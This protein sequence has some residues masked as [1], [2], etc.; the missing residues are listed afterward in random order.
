[1]S[2]MSFEHD[3]P[4]LQRTRN[5]RNEIKNPRRNR[6]GCARCEKENG[7]FSLLACAHNNAGPADE[8]NNMSRMNGSSC[9]I[10]IPLLG[11]DRQSGHRRLH[12]SRDAHVC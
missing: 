6:Q 9:A 7:E 8:A 12:A 11:G 1:M 4:H 2:P 5:E 3:L 10:T